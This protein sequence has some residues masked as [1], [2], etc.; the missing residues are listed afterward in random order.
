MVICIIFLF[1]LLQ[2]GYSTEF[3]MEEEENGSGIS[4]HIRQ[5][6]EH[7]KQPD[8]VGLPG[9]PIPD[10]MPIPDIK[11]QQ[12][13]VKINLQNVTVHGLSK[14]RIDQVFSN[15]A[16][17]QVEAALKYARVE[18]RGNY[19]MMP[20]LGS[21]RSDKFNISL[22]G[23]YFEALALLEVAHLGNLEATD[24]KMDI[25]FDDMKLDFKNVGFLASLLQGMINALSSFVFDSV[26]PYILKEVNTNVRA[27][28]NKILKSLKQTFPNSI[29]PFD[30]IVAELRKYVREN[31]YDPYKIPDYN[32]NPGIFGVDITNIWISGLATFFRVGNVTVT[33]SNN[34]L[35]TYIHI[36]TR[37]LHGQCKWEIPGVKKLASPGITSFTI[38]HMEIE[39]KFNQSLDIRKTPVLEELKLKIGNIQLRMNGLGTFDYLLE[40][41]ANFLPNILRYQISDAIE[42]PLKERIQNTLNIIDLENQ[43]DT[44]LNQFDALT[45]GNNTGD[46]DF[47][48]VYDDDFF[49]DISM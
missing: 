5:I 13:L 11:F 43:V 22:V 17:M 20:L 36:S 39:T 16:K 9:I 6:I 37:R 49:E 42:T 32:Y 40:F 31:D 3:S 4:N 2:A 7:Y 15:M 28:I 18:I 45:Y 8:P 1:L 25:T 34:T 35:S 41:V 23:V 27:D 14:F 48:D 10:P 46:L 33:M 24:I 30:L 19:T 29:P 26:K 12:S 38:E 21:V 47:P 44:I